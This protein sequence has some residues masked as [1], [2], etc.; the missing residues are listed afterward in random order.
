MEKSYQFKTNLLK[1]HK[2]DRRDMSLLPSENEFSFFDGIKISVCDMSLKNDSDDVIMTALRDFEDYLFT[3]MNVSA[4][5]CRSFDDANMKLSINT[6]LAD[7]SGYMGYRIT[8]SENDVTIEGYDVRGIAQALYYIE[9][10]MNI[11]R[12]P[13]L[14]K[15]ITARKAMFVPRTVHSPLGMFEYPEAALSIVAHMGFDC[16]DLWMKDAFTSKRGDYLDLNLLS[17]RAAKYGIDICVGLYALHDKHP[18][19]EG[20]QEYYDKLYGEFFTACP[21]IKYITLVGEAT[22][23]PSRDPRVGKS[24]YYKNFEDN[25]PTG[26]TSPGWFPCNDYPQWV[27]MINNSIHKFNPDALLILSTYN[28]GFC[29][30]EDRIKL[31]ENL[32]TDIAICS[33]WDMFEQK[34]VGNSVE[35]VVDYSLSAAGPGKPFVSEAIAALK[36]GIRLHA[37]SQTAGNTGDVGTIPYEPMPGQWIK[38]YKGMQKA[39]KEWNLHGLRDSIHYAFYPSFICELEKYS[40]FTN[41]I[42]PEEY[43]EKLV[44]RDH[45]KNASQVLE[46]LKCFDEA[47][48]HY[49]PTNEDQYGAYR[50]GPAYPLWLEDTYGMPA[51][52]PEGGRQPSRNHAMFGNSIYFPTYTTESLGRNSLPGVRIFDELNEAYIMRDLLLKG[53]E[54]MRACVDKTEE[55][56]KLLNLGEYIYRCVNTTIN[57]KRHYILKQKLNIAETHEAASKLIDEVEALLLE[58]KENVLA[59]IPLVQYDSI[60][61]WEPSMEYV[62]DEKGLRWKL[63]Q[64]E[65]ELSVIIPKFR[66]ANTLIDKF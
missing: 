53:I 5:I 45:G 21:R 51:S 26:K 36:R 8:V 19:D 17:E 30:D 50:A 63:R 62:A 49:V 10:T 52:I 9:D 12:A 18:E 40:F 16:I 58:E 65:H 14:E 34:R 66:K 25:I 4:M 43:L 31:I 32:P 24:P 59:A 2:K 54:I 7:A 47:I 39:Y 61:G 33:T 48:T 57:T 35:D 1:L 15:G 55:T 41:G 3:S 29:D 23:F 20:A 27:E 13:F 64:L 44:T 11:R 6:D 37:N 28:W 46:A 60:L 42:D 56:K 22:N 38:R